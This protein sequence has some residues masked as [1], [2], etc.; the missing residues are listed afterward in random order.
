MTQRRL[1]I[2]LLF[3]IAASVV[4]IL[5]LNFVGPDRQVTEEIYHR[6]DLD[7]PQFRREMGVLLGPSVVDGNLISDLQNGT[8]I[9][10]AMLAAIASAEETITF[11]TFVYWSGDIG[12]QFAEALAERARDSVEVRVLVD[13]AGA[14]KMDPASFDLMEAAGVE[15]HWYRPLEWYTLAR[16]N[17][18][19]HRKILVVDGTVGFTGGVGIADEWDGDG[20]SPEEWRDA[21]FQVEG[22]VVAQLQAAFLDNWIETTGE[23]LNGP[24]YFPPLDSVG[25]ASAHVFT[26]SP[27]GGSDSMRLMYMMAIAAAEHT[28]DLAAAYFVPDGLLSDALVAAQ[29]R[30]VRVRIVL[31]GEH[32]D[33]ELVSISSKGTWGPLLEAGVLIAEFAPSMYHTKMLLVD[34]IFTSVGSTNFDIRSFELNDEASLNIYDATFA[35][36]MTEVF[37]ADLANAEP[38]SYEQWQNRPWTEKLAETLVRPLKSQL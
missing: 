27:A 12:R 15:I 25:T 23:I 31:P 7:S 14:Q 36:R 28:I 37:E 20:D 11:E 4:V 35:A 5:G 38:Y 9:F 33:S 34:G 13:W 21:H 29:E 1:A 17:N 32:M 2:A 19:T 16:L 26:S 6:Y 3:L 8:E 24:A 22:P 10:P 30:G 18:R